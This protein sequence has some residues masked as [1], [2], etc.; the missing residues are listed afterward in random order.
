MIIIR[1]TF[2]TFCSIQ[3]ATV[4]VDL[5]CENEMREHIYV[6]NERL[7][8]LN[9]SNAIFIK[10]FSFTIMQQNLCL[11]LIWL[12][13]CIKSAIVNP[14]DGSSFGIRVKV[15]KVSQGLTTKRSVSIICLMFEMIWKIHHFPDREYNHS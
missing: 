4:S 12:L 11:Y 5:E 15:L 1:D 6:D 7:L 14:R 13:G 2:W 3:L 8:I 9:E 10:S